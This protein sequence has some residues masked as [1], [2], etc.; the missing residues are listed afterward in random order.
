MASSKSYCDYVLEQLAELEGISY[1][2]MM[3]EFLLYCNGVLFGGIYDNCLLIKKTVSNAKF[4][5][6][7]VIPYLNA[8]PMYL[9]ENLEDAETLLQ[10]IITTVTDLKNK[11]L[12]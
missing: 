12:N 11:I 4:N 6:P 9:V 5:L 2:P 10:M 7:N 8:K 3:G 1:R